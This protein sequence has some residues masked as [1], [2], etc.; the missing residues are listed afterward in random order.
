M[1]LTML[2]LLPP[3]LQHV[4]RLVDCATERWEICA[5][6]EFLEW[7]ARRHGSF[8]FYGTTQRV[9]QGNI[10]VAIS[11]VCL[12]VWICGEC[13]GIYVT[14]YPRRVQGDY[15]HQWRAPLRAARDQR[16]RDN[17]VTEL[18]TRLVRLVGWSMG[19]SLSLYLSLILSAARLGP[20][21]CLGFL[22][23]KSCAD[24]CDC[25]HFYSVRRQSATRLPR[26]P[27]L[28]IVTL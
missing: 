13:A 14:D 23:V 20:I 24:C 5:Q 19:R 16:Q 11:V 25:I 8:G 6:P 9:I 7:G 27:V 1:L 17:R 10:C 4:R 28:L 18:A 21:I 3:M 2:P 22:C 12:C 15:K 26:D